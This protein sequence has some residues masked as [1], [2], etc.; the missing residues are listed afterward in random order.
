MTLTALDSALWA[1]GFVGHVALLSVLVSRGRWKQFPVFSA[2]IAFEIVNTATLF[3]I[4][5]KER[6]DTYYLAYW[7]SSFADCAFQIGLIFEIARAVLRPA[8][9]WVQDAR[10]SFL[11]WSAVG[12]ALATAVVFSINTSAAR[13]IALWQVRTIL[14]TS[15][16]TLELF[17]SMSAAANRLGLPWR[18]HVMAVGQGIAALA[19]TSV[20]SDIGHMHYGWSHEFVIFDYV[21]EV[22][23]LGCLLYWGISLWQPERERA[24]LS[25]EMQEYLLALHRRVQYDLERQNTENAPL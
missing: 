2:M 10:A 12:I 9:A 11:G 8:K 6:P 24:P 25:K 23:Y 21:S 22:V 14:F 17:L 15:V 20:L 19:V 5:P 18:S 13:G 3:L 1:A 4:S 7:I 16:L